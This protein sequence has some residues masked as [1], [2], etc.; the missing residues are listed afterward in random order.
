[1]YVVPLNRM[2]RKINLAPVEEPSKERCEN[3][4]VNFLQVKTFNNS[5]DYSGQMASVS[6]IL[7]YI[8]PVEYFT[9]AISSIFMLVLVNQ[10]IFHTVGWF[11]LLSNNALYIHLIVFQN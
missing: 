3:T 8:I 1:M 9:G 10:P 11:N 5:S 7:L 2:I 4:H 6:V